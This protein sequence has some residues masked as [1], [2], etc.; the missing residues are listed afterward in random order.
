MKPTADGGMP[1]NQEEKELKYNG[2]T[3]KFT[4]Y[5]TI[6][7]VTFKKKSEIGDNDYSDRVRGT[8]GNESWGES[9]AP[10]VQF[11]GT[12]VKCFDDNNQIPV[13]SYVLN[14]NNLGG[15]QGL[16]YYRTVKTK[17]KGFRGWL[18]TI[19]DRP[20]KGGLEYE[21][22][23]VVDQVNGDV[24]A[25]DGIEAEQQHNANIYNLNGQLMRQGATSTEGLPSGLYIVGGK[26]VVVK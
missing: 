16:W 14:G 6:A 9:N 26:K 25:I 15:T 10:Q 2:Q 12:Y 20:S 19:G 22:E 17:T 3:T 8:E 23:G 24:T 13:N 4:S 1:T 7:G 21:I 5:Y 18:E 11:V